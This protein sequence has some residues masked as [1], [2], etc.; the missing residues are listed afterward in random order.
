MLYARSLKR[1]VWRN[2]NRLQGLT[3][4]ILNIFRRLP[5]CLL[6][7]PGLGWEVGKRGGCLGCFSRRGSKK[8]RAYYLCYWSSSQFIVEVNIGLFASCVKGPC[9]RNHVE[10]LPRRVEASCSHKRRTDSILMPIVLKIGCSTSWYRCDGQ[11]HNVLY[12]QYT[13]NLIPLLRH[14]D[15]QQ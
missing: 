9:P 13:L 15:Q 12:I 5:T 7:Q 8:G 3:A 10:S 2:S 4:I 14:L 11:I 6:V 1:M